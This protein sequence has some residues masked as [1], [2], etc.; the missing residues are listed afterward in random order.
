MSEQ[1]FVAMETPDGVYQVSLDMKSMMHPQTLLAW[2]L[3]REPLDS[4][5]G[6]PLRLATPLKYG[7]KQIKRVGQIQFSSERTIDY[8]EERGYDW[9]AGL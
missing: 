6:A 4:D 5:H 3:N 7:I 9:W 1:P 8:W 2:E